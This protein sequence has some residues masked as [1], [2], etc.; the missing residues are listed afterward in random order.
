MKFSITYETVTPESAEHGDA[1]ER[2]FILEAGTLRD[3]HDALR[4]EGRAIEANSSHGA[5]GS[6]TFAPDVDYRTSAETTKSLHFPRTITDAS[7]CRVARLF[8]YKVNA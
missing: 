7:A 3:A 1:A 8:G 5:P 6:L 2:G 4:F